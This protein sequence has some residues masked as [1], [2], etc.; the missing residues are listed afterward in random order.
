MIRTVPLPYPQLNIKVSLTSWADIVSNW[1]ISF[2]TQALI[3]TL[4]DSCVVHLC[5]SY[6]QL[7]ENELYFFPLTTTGSQKRNCHA[8]TCSRV[9]F[10]QSRLSFNLY[11]H[12]LVWA[13]TT[14]GV[15]RVESK[16]RSLASHG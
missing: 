1:L 5:H 9:L 16:E 4:V 10:D 12:P 14:D 13:T 7:S 2:Q 3:R 6:R 8:S 15:A 11:T